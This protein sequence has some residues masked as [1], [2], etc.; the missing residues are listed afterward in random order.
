MV[1]VVGTVEIAGTAAGRE[2]NPPLV[3]VLGWPSRIAFG[4]VGAPTT[5][6]PLGSTGGMSAKPALDEEK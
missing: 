5:P 3:L 1:G 4:P 2:F 6:S